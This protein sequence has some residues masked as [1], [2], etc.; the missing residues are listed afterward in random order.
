[1]GFVNSNANL[2]YCNFQKLGSTWLVSWLCRSRRTNLWRPL[3][4]V[5]AAQ[6]APANWCQQLVHQMACCIC[7]DGVSIAVSVCVPIGF[8][9]PNAMYVCLRMCVCGYVWV[10]VQRQRQRKV[11]KVRFMDTNAVAAVS[12]CTTFPFRCCPSNGSLNSN[13]VGYLFYLSQLIGVTKMN[14]YTIR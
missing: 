12:F 1:M 8:I 7:F 3:C 13:K 10:Q 9:N 5:A 6:M 11:N 2:K 14:L 4:L